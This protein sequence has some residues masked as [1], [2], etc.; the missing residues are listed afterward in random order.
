MKNKRTN[1]KYEYQRTLKAW[2]S[3]ED[4]RDIAGV[5]IDRIRKC[6]TIKSAKEEVR[7]FDEAIAIYRD[8]HKGT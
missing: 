5:F 7:A 3:A 4:E 8:V 2:A 6:R 1:W